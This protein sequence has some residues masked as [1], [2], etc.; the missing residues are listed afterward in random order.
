[1]E[2]DKKSIFPINIQQKSSVFLVKKSGNG[3]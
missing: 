3:D 2:F 1:M